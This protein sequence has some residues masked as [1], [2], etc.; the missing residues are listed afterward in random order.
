MITS[1]ACPCCPNELY[2]T[3]HIEGPH[4]AKQSGPPLE[5]DSKGPFMI[6]P[7]CQCRVDF[8]GSGQLQPSPVQSCEKPK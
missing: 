8:I 2:T 7:H 3:A 1:V 5:Q 6:C 4:F